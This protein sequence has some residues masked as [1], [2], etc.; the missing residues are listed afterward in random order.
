[1]FDAIA[2]GLRQHLLAQPSEKARMIL[3]IW[4]EGARNPRIASMGRSVDCG[5]RDGLVQVFEA[6]KASG[7]AAASL[8][9]EFAARLLFT[10]VGG[11][12]KRLA[13]EASFDVEAETAMVLGV[14]RALFNGALRPEGAGENPERG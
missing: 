7:E 13:H 4:S 14:L 11:L 1:V 10:L 3:E 9:S 8:D 12:F 6:A 2:T 5:V